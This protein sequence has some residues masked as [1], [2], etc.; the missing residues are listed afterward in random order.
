MANKNEEIVK[1]EKDWNRIKKLLDESRD[2]FAN[3]S[4]IIR[5]PNEDVLNMRDRIEVFK[6]S[7]VNLSNKLIRSKGD[8]IFKNQIKRDNL[9]GSQGVFVKRADRSGQSLS[10]LIHNE[11]SP[12]LA[13]YALIVGIIDKPAVVAANLEQEQLESLPYLE[14]INPTSILDFQWADSGELLWFKYCITVPVDRSN[15]RNFVKRY[16][17]Y[18]GDTAIVLWTKNF[19]TVLSEDEKK[20]LEETP[21]PFGIVP[22]AFQSIYLT[23]GKS[24][25]RVPFFD[26]S[27]Y[28]IMG[29]NLLA[30]ANWE[31]FKN[32]QPPLLMNEMD[33]TD[34]RIEHQ[35]D[36]LTNKKMLVNQTKEAGVMPV[37]DAAFKPSYLTKD[38]EIIEKAMAQSEK[39][40]TLAIENEANPMSVET[41][42]VPQSGVA[43]GYDFQDTNADTAAHADALEAFEK[44]IWKIY[45]VIMGEGNNVV[46]TYPNDFSSVNANAKDE[47]TDSTPAGA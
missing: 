32:L 17:N 9:S 16:P 39:Y 11:A 47:A 14:I 26:S 27:D 42:K 35:R 25:G 6:K 7:F 12:S 8:M 3:E 33:Y 40:F 30:G 21:N 36:P 22:I 46:V 5:Y 2:I 1:V 23:P 31:I 20:V 29:N 13:S 15:P 4:F 24:I 18:K 38:L 43:K 45:S 41:L 19:Y 37:S 34:N 28:I 10:E 44:Q